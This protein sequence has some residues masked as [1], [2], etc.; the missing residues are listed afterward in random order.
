ML[1]A[2][3]G[4]RFVAAFAVFLFHSREKFHIDSWKLGSLGSCAVAF[5]FVLSGFILT[6]VYGESLKRESLRGFFV[7]RFARIWPVHIAT[8]VLFVVVMRRGTFPADGSEVLSALKQAFLLQTWSTDLTSVLQLNGV[9]WSISVEF[10]FYALFPFLCFLSRKALLKAYALIALGSVLALAVAE[11]WVRQDPAALEGAR[12]VFHF[13]P[14]TRLFEFTTGIVAARWFAVAGATRRN[15]ALD[16][17]LE[18]AVLALA[19]GAFWAINYTPTIYT[20]EQALGTRVLST[21]LVHGPAY[22][23]PFTAV[24]VVFARSRGLVARALSLPGCVYLGEISYAFYMVHSIVLLA[25]VRYGGAI[26]SDW[27]L[28]LLASLA[29]TLAASALL[30]EG[31]ELPFRDFF[32]K[33]L[34]KRGKEALPALARGQVAFLRNVTV[35][36]SIAVLVLTPVGIGRV[37]R[38]RGAVLAESHVAR[39]TPRLRDV[40]FAGEARVLGVVTERHDNSLELTVVYERLPE[41]RRDLFLHISDASGNPV[42]QGSFKVSSVGDEKGRDVYIATATLAKSQLEG[43]TTLGIG[44]W[45]QANGAARADRGPL[46]MAGHR[47]DVF[48]VGQRKRRAPAEE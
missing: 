41:A 4:L 19:F 2:L 42:R 7:A 47:L 25:V 16:T 10:L 38:L 33:L 5:F 18:V 15:V 48:G 30:H 14:P 29:M 43:A 37:S 46:S 31:I 1:D 21:Y 32:S 11:F 39:S 26:T 20:I 28:G 40:T 34:T 35:F 9:S 17:L 44:F 12:T 3:T 8:L 45:S 27:Q 22:A 6:Y 36:G 24:I 13:A 23:L